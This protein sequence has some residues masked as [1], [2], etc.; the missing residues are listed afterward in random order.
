[1]PQSPHLKNDFCKNGIQS[2]NESEYQCLTDSKNSVNQ[3]KK[4][5][6]RTVKHHTL[7]K[8][9]RHPFTE[10]LENAYRQPLSKN[11]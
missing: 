10:Q 2:H 8:E 3:R 1:M 9:A 7:L 5:N 11:K 4:Y 6:V